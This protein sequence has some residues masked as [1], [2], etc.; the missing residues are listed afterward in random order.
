MDA[1]RESP[2]KK[3]RGN[4]EVNALRDGRLPACLLRKVPL[5][6]KCVLA[7]NAPRSHEDAVCFREATFL[8]GAPHPS[9]LTEPPTLAGACPSALLP[10]ELP[11]LPEELVSGST[12]VLSAVQVETCA[13]AVRSLERRLCREGRGDH[14]V[15]KRRG[16]YLLGDGTGFGKGRVISAVIL[17]FWR[18]GAR[19]HTWLSASADLIADATRDL[20]DVTGGEAPNYFGGHLPIKALSDWPVDKTGPDSTDEGVLFASYSLLARDVRRIRQLFTWLHDVDGGVLVMDEAHRARNSGTKIGHRML[21]LQRKLPDAGVM[22]VSATVASR[23]EHVGFMPRLGLWGVWGSGFSSFE[24]FSEF[25]NHGGMPIMELLA[26]ECKQRGLASSRM[27]TLEGLEFNVRPCVTSKSFRKQYDAACAF[28]ASIREILAIISDSQEFRKGCKRNSTGI[29]REFWSTGQRFFKQLLLCGKVPAC[30]RAAQEA[31]QGKNAVVISM[32]TTGSTL[33]A[34]PVEDPETAQIVDAVL[35]GGPRVILERLLR[36]ERLFP[37]KPRESDEPVEWAV[38]LVQGAVDNLATL[39]LP[40]NPLDTLLDELGGPEAVAEMSGRSFQIVNGA[41]KRRAGGNSANKLERAAFQAGKKH[42]AV[43]SEA[44]S[45]GFSLHADP[46]AVAAPR[47][48]IMFAL[49]LPFSAEKVIQAFGRVH[50]AGQAVVP[51]F[52]ILVSDLQSELRFVS[53]IAKRVSALS[54][55]SRGSQSSLTRGVLDAFDLSHAL[56]KQAIQRFLSAVQKAAPKKAGRGEVDSDSDISE[57]SASD[58]GAVGGRSDEQASNDEVDNDPGMDK[59]SACDDT[60]VLCDMLLNQNEGEDSHD[61]ERFAGRARDA[62]ERAGITLSGLTMFEEENSG[63]GESSLV[64]VFLNRMLMIPCDLQNQILGLINHLCDA[65]VTDSSSDGFGGIAC[66][67]TPALLRWAGLPP[68]P[69]KILRIDPLE[70]S[71]KM[72]SL[73]AVTLSVDQ[74]LSWQTVTSLHDSSPGSCFLRPKRDGQRI[75]PCLLCLPRTARTYVVLRP[76]GEALVWNSAA[77][78]DRPQCSVDEAKH[79]WHDGLAAAPVEG[80]SVTLLCGDILALGPRLS[81]VLGKGKGQRLVLRRAVLDGET[82]VGAILPSR[83]P[84][85][86]V[87]AVLRGRETRS[88]GALDKSS[89]ESSQSFSFGSEEEIQEQMTSSSETSSSTSSSSSSS[90]DTAMVENKVIDLDE[91]SGSD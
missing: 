14:V 55:M 54:A 37:T 61:F 66:L 16:G 56:A 32:W 23:A 74:R 82:M 63:L 21:A 38:S 45:V 44:G 42:I 31:L 2:L 15:A 4:D 26:I 6:P 86:D 22:Y 51:Q 71:P 62:L 46:S 9:A 11:D 65:L 72:L 59:S 67:N 91:S 47:R 49:E 40:G 8:H 17:H 68:R 18:R 75:A 85:E 73:R 76:C 29:W 33:K 30:V 34:K 13:L 70:V 53:G 78:A 19:R 25:L 28:W 48:R 84:I 80:Q 12:P 64:V 81:R 79:R 83:C 43:I 88:G 39:S 57:P 36:N 52:S 50:R 3:R 10:S 58:D 5:R 24:H 20:R 69:I 27:L 1:G 89:A 90:S 41:R 87:A 60:K 7:A 77:V 35:E